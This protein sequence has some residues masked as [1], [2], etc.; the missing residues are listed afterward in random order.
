V[1]LLRLIFIIRLIGAS[2]AT[3]WGINIGLAAEGA[4]NPSVNCFVS[5]KFIGYAFDPIPQLN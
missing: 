4:V 5:I 1:I 3:N 2:P